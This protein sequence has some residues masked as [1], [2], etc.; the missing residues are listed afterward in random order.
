M[1]Q[2]L[3]V[4]TC[5]PR[6]VEVKEKMHRQQL[7]GKHKIIS[8]RHTSGIAATAQSHCG[9]S[10][11]NDDD[12]CSNSGSSDSSSSGGDDDRDG[13]K[14][15]ELEKKKKEMSKLVEWKQIAL[16]RRSVSHYFE[17]ISFLFQ[18]SKI[19]Y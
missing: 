4:C 14:K 2:L 3:V 10:H 1:L 6:I 7:R 17:G 9:H 15:T 16:R 13:G 5:R 12:S 19:T 8:V 11:N 18:V